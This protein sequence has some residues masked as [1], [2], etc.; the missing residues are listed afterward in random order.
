MGWLW[1]WGVLWTG[2]VLG[3]PVVWGAEGTATALR[4]SPI[5]PSVQVGGENRMVIG[6]CLV[7]LVQE[8]QTPAQAAGVLVEIPVQEGMAVSAGQ[9]LA[10]IDDTQPMSDQQIAAL[11]LQAAQEKAKSDISI[12]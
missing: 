12:R 1:A 11:K 7:S 6:Q 4:T 8:V 2:A 3:T 10:R 5:P 9:L